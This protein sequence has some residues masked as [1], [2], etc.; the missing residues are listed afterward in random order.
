ML[1]QQI[2]IENGNIPVV[3]L[4]IIMYVMC[5]DTARQYELSALEL[6]PTPRLL[7]SAQNPRQKSATISNSISKV[8]DSCGFIYDLFPFKWAKLRGPVHFVCNY[9][10]VICEFS[11]YSILGMRKQETHTFVLKNN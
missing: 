8:S 3:T 2:G 6:D 7:R 9:S 11:T 5:C 4:Y 1:S 10:Q